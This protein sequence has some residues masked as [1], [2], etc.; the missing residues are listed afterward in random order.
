M[1]M[2]PHIETMLDDQRRRFRAGQ[3][4][5]LNEYCRA[6]PSLFDDSEALLDL[7]YNEVLLRREVGQTPALND[8]VRKFPRL[9]HELELIFDVDGGLEKNYSQ[10]VETGTENDASQT[11]SFAKGRV[12]TRKSPGLENFASNAKVSESVDRIATTHASTPATEPQKNIELRIQ[13]AGGK[14]VSVAQMLRSRLLVTCMVLAVNY[15]QAFSQLNTLFFASSWQVVLQLVLSLLFSCMAMLLWLRK[16]L[17]LDWLR[18][19]EVIAFAL[20]LCQLSMFLIERVWQQGDLLRSFQDGEVY[21]GHLL[22]TIVLCY[23]PIIVAYGVLIPNTGWR[24]FLMTCLMSSLPIAI[25]LGGVPWYWEQ[26]ESHLSLFLRGIAWVVSWM[27]VAVVVASFGSYRMDELSQQV[28]AA[29]KFGSYRLI[30]KM[31]SGGMGEVYLGEHELLKQPCAIKVIRPDRVSDPQT[32]MRFEREVQA[33]ARL[34]HP[35]SIEIYDYGRAEDGTF[36]YVM[37]YLPGKTLDQLVAVGGPLPVARAI[38]LWIQLCGPLREAHCIGLIHRDIKPANIIVCQRG[39]V[40]DLCKLLDFGLVKNVSDSNQLP[41]LTQS[42][43]IAGTP[44]YMSPEQVTS[45]RDID[46]RSDIY[47]LG[48]VAYFMLSA[49]PLFDGVALKVMADHLNSDPTSIRLHNPEI[50]DALVQVIERCLAKDRDDRF[51]SVGDL[52]AALKKLASVYVWSEE[53]AEQCW[54]NG[55]GVAPYRINRTSSMS[56][57]S[58][59]SR[60]ANVVPPATPNSQMPVLDLQKQQRMPG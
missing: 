2:S 56:R 14:T 38:H 60:S 51:A 15:A 50:P 12:L 32:L 45:A 46:M 34:K 49:K 18:R 9:Q 3:P 27:L 1:T 44:A 22:N 40:A 41:S 4:R 26:V 6:H 31:G 11:H 24:C 47:S 53:E 19:I 58:N 37:E 36:Y 42:D 23:F 43:A 10:S 25:L 59:Q 57:V 33:T 39:G 52:F 7:I 54:E 55:Q 35:N 8:Y 30:H 20:P 17:T 28:A 48:A 16:E 5:L 13:N 29:R 21:R